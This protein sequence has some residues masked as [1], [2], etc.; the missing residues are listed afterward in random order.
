[1]CTEVPKD[2]KQGPAKDNGIKL[3]IPKKG[4]AL[5]NTGVILSTSQ[6]FMCGY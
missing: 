2:F 5:R 6:D 1:M 3:Q 4:K